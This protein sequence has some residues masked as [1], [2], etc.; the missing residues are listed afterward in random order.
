[1]IESYSMMRELMST[2]GMQLLIS[3]VLI[4]LIGLMFWW[5]QKQ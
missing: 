5:G 3:L 2:D 1:M 4:I